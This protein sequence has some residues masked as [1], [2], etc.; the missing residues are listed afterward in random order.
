MNTQAFIPALELFDWLRGA[1]R[2]R[3]NVA[4]RIVTP[5]LET[6]TL[7]LSEGKLV[8]VKCEGR[9]PLD[10]LVLLAECERLSFSYASVRAVER[11]ELMSTDMF[12]KWLDTASDTIPNVAD[13]DTDDLSGV[14]GSGPRPGAPDSGRWS[15]ALRG[16]QARKGSTAVVVA[17]VVV[18]MVI[19]LVGLYATGGDRADEVVETPSRV[20]AGE[21]STRIGRSDTEIIRSSIGEPTTWR[22]GRAI[23]LEGLVFVENRVRLVIEPGVTVLGGP[24][25]ALIVTRGA[26]IQA[27][28]T[29]AEPIVFTSAQPV[30]ERTGGDWG[31]VVLLGDAPINR[32]ETSIEGITQD[33]TRSVFGG[34]DRSSNCGVLEYGTHRIRRILDRY[35]QRAERVDPRWVR[36]RDLHTPCSGASRPR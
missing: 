25:A 1:V 30:G 29:P 27:R 21:P 31:G 4:L 18:V 36:E 24:G 19:A 10:A 23:R 5:Q 13:S 22:A 11:R 33:D 9:G 34:I 16:G 26:S 6:I 3:E 15:G 20:T 7:R 14:L 12:L 8:L 32:G 35:G 17:A 2:R 28:G